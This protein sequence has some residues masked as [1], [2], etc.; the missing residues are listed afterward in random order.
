MGKKKHEWKS[1][2]WHETE[3]KVKQVAAGLKY[4]G[5][6]PGDKIII[7]SENRPE[8]IISDLA[9]NTLNA[10]TV[11]AYVT[12]TEDDHRY[13]IEHSDAKAVIVSDNILAN[14]IALALSKVTSCNLLITIDE[15][16]GF[17]PEGLKVESLK[18][19][20]KLVKK[21][22]LT[23]LHNL[24]TIDKDDICCLIYTSGTGGRPKGVMLTHKSIYHNILGADDLV[25]ASW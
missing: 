15:Y 5:I 20:S 7:V 12:N 24:N 21:I 4:H 22:Y 13:I 16:S 25:K 8:W 19:Y 10:I 6:M 17:M 11:P 9:I 2:S 1:L 3:I 14:R 23:A 18:N